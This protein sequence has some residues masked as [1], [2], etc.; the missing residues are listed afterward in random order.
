[1]N[2]LSGR[3]IGKLVPTSLARKAALLGMLAAIAHCGAQTPIAYYP[4]NG[5]GADASGNGFNG[6][7][8]GTTPTTDRYGNSGGALLF[9]NGTDRVVCGNPAA[10][11]FA[12]PFTISAWVNLNGSRFNSYVVAKYDTTIG[13]AHAYGLGIANIALPYTFVGNDFGYADMIA[14]SAPMNANQWYA[15][16]TVYDGNS[17]NLYANG[18][19]AA[20]SF[21]GPFPSFINDAPL[22]IGGTFDNYVVGGAIDDVRIYNAALTP[23]E[24]AAQYAA[25]VPP[26]PPNVGGLVAYYK[27]NGGNAGDNSG[28]GLDGVVA[29]AEPTTDRDGRKNKALAFDGADDRV[30]LGNPS[31]LN[32]AGNFTLSAWIKMDGAQVDKYVV[33][34]Y[35][36]N[37]STGTSS[38]FCYGLGTDGI[39]NAYGFVGSS[40]G[41]VD[42]RAGPSLNDGS[43]HAIAFAY[44]GA[45]TIRLYVDGVLVGSRPV[46][47]Q[48]PFVNAV[49]VTIGSQSLG[50]GFGGSIDEVR[51]YNKALSD[52]EVAAQYQI[53]LPKVATLSLKS[54][55]VARYKLDGNAVDS[56]GNNLHGV[57]TGTGLAA[58]RF[59]RP[60]KALYFNG[61]SDLINCGNAS[62]FNF[63]NSFT[64][65]TWLKVDGDQTEKYL[66]TKF[67]D[68]VEHAYGL[69]VGQNT[70]PYGFL[71]GNFGYIDQPTFANMNDNNWHMVSMVYEYGNTLRL[72]LDA[73]LVGSRFAGSFPPFINS[74]PLTIGGRLSGQNFKGSMDD[75]RLY[76]RAL[77]EEELTVLTETK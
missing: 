1:M 50:Q 11:N 63:T 51:I 33:A 24:I 61:V 20:Q 30:N 23:G 36:F 3:L 62:Q 72:Y 41:F 70:D 9:A 15:L 12:G 28:N 65:T 4:L 76:N 13:P 22:T 43:W 35:D 75:A 16:S 18:E 66:I 55:L 46:P 8:I 49:P 21:V 40:S 58:D 73:N 77:S 45:D 37:F 53:D 31:Q 39:A 52:N 54:G 27:F 56:S 42:L 60:N 38:Q 47:V 67:G 14:F 69:G 2:R 48:P 64:L 59:D 57:L 68:T 44:Q 32:F 74:A 26:P 10:F 19:L 7:L 5:D 34:K 25:D 6:S 71:G 17:L 29:G